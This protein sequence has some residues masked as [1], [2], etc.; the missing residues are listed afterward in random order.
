MR[1][2]GASKRVVHVTARNSTRARQVR[3]DGVLGTEADGEQKQ[4]RPH[5]TFADKVDAMSRWERHAFHL[6]ETWVLTRWR[7]VTDWRPGHVHK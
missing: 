5:S 3:S 4:S 2:T 1:G 6:E 7:R